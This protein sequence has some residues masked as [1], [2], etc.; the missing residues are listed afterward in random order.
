[1]LTHSKNDPL[2]IALLS[3]SP[4]NRAIL[5][6]FFAGAGRHLFKAVGIGEATAL[7]V[8]YDH[9]GAKDEWAQHAS[10]G[11]P[12]IILS[13][14]PIDM[15]NTVWI[16]KPLTSKALTEAAGRVYAL[17]AASALPLPVNRPVAMGHQEAEVAAPPL[18]K[19]SF[20]HPFGLSQRPT[21]KPRTVVLDIPDDD[22]EEEVQPQPVV[23]SPAETVM[24]FDPAENDISM[25]EIARPVEP[26][27]PP[28][29]AERRWRE[30]CGNS[31]DVLN[32][33]DI[34]LFTPENY[35]LT[36]LQEA[37]R[38]ARQSNQQVELKFP[39][40]G[41]ALLIPETN[42]VYCSLDTRSDEFAMLCNNPVQTGQVTLHI[43]SSTEQAHWEGQIR[44]SQLH[45]LEAFMWVASL[46]TA[47]GR[48]S[49]N[50]D[51]NQRTA[52]KHWP[53]MTRLEQFPQIMRIAALWNQRP[54]TPPEIAKALGIPQ[55]YVFS[56]CTA[57]STLNL[58]ELDQ[59]K[60]KSREK[61]KPKESRGL[62]SRLLKRLLGGGAK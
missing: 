47:Q 36:N 54:A 12:G 9:M 20:Q 19:T 58:F 45:D 57:A 4:H 23:T 41:M 35:L 49:R 30:L 21:L 15:P 40:G 8:D 55:R 25:E 22:D 43:L 5:E 13:V 33:A 38:L 46:L 61:E 3:I 18:P 31:D 44:D 29:V 60:L 32:V 42:Q 48:L 6:F 34:V 28:E 16:A 51:V 39:N 50:V 10:S 24:A 53:N 52:L 62:F 59:T 17:S 27:V 37:V 1:M 56:F 26:S 7:V 14:H 2:K 11:K